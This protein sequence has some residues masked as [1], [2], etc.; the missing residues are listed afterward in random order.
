MIKKLILILLIAT[1]CLAA[2]WRI[3]AYYPSANDSIW[4]VKYVDGAAVDSEMWATQNIDTS[5]TVDT[6]VHTQVTL[7]NWY[8]GEDSAG[9]W[10]WEFAPSVT[11]SLV[12]GALT[13]TYYTIDTVNND[14]LAN[15]LL[16]ILDQT[17]S[18]YILDRTTT[19]GYLSTA[20]DAGDT[21]LVYAYAQPAYNSP[22]QD[23]L[24][25]DSVFIGS[26]DTT[27]DIQFY[28]MDI[29]S[30]SAANT[31]RM[32]AHAY[33]AEGNPVKGAVMTATIN[34]LGGQ[35]VQ[36]TCSNFIPIKFKASEKSDHTGMVFLDLLQNDC[37][38]GSNTY[39]FILRLKSGSRRPLFKVDMAVPSGVDSAMVTAQ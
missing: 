37:M 3:A 1:G 12:S 7:K 30:P 23:V 33:D 24:G 15:I 39:N 34:I 29:G 2:T 10:V 8:E 16:E 18:R 32:Y 9:S 6:D 27:I 13:M 28:P 5:I 4:F 36:D 21:F 25:F 11:T 17:G 14:T 38:T 22:G 26:N 20:N 31:T 19:A 35:Q